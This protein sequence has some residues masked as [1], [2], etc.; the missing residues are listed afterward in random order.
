[1]REIDTAW[2]QSCKYSVTMQNLLGSADNLT[3]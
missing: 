2:Q 1:M 3:I